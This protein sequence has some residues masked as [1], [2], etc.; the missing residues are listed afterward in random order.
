LKQL[1][2]EKSVF[3]GMAKEAGLLG[4]Q[5]QHQHQ[6][7]QSRKQPSLQHEQQEQKQRHNSEN[8]ID[9]SPKEKSKK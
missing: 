9:L 1:K 6:E 8:L 2:N 3:Y 5:N 4:G 7:K